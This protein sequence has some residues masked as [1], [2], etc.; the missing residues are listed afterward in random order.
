M[1]ACWGS[2]PV[3]LVQIILLPEERWPWCVFIS[4]VRSSRLL[5]V[6][7][8]RVCVFFLTCL[9]LYTLILYAF[10]FFF[11]QWKA[12]QIGQWT[13]WITRF[14]WGSPCGSNVLYFMD[15]YE[16]T[17]LMR[18]VLDS[19]LCG[20]KVP[21]TGS[22]RNPS[23]LTARGWAR[24]KTPSG[25]DRRSWTTRATIPVCWGKPEQHVLRRQ[26]QALKPHF[27]AAHISND[28]PPPPRRHLS[29]GQAALSALLPYSNV[30]DAY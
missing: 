19:A 15:I 2:A 10:F 25:S 7:L 29:G 3:F 24:R 30:A 4:A 26:T 23:A 12:A 20:T 14:F 9:H 28:P 8:Q 22:S 21:D 18:R 11:F 1:V 16:P 27:E 13:I 5:L 17:T 6:H